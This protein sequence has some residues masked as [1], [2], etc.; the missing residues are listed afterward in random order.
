VSHRRADL[1]RERQVID[2][3]CT[4]TQDGRFWVEVVGEAG[5][6]IKELISSDSGRTQPSLA[7]ILG[8]TASVVSLDVV[9]VET[10]NEYGE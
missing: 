2:I 3:G 5:L 7:Q 8:R 4:G 10:A 9:L 1:V 6:Y